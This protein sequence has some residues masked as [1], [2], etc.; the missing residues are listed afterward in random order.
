MAS[1]V[2]SETNPANIW[3][4][5]RFNKSSV[6]V[7]EP[8]LV[9]ITVYTSTWFTSP[10]QFSEIQVPESMMV[11]YEQRTGSM[12]K[13][14]GNKT[15]PAIE[16]KYVV[17]PFREG[18]NLFPALTIVTESPPEGDY[19]GKRRVVKSTER[20]FMVKHPPAGVSREKWLTAF[21]V[22]IS[23]TWNQPLSDLKQGDVLER[24]ITLQA[25]GAVAALIPPLDLPEGAFGNIYPKP[26]SLSNLQNEASFTGT[27]TETWTYL[28]ESEGSF[29]L[30]EVSVSWFD[31]G[32]DNLET[33]SLPEKGIEILENPNLDF[34]L[35]MQDSLRG[36]LEEGQS[37]EAEPF[38]FMGLKWWQLLIAVISGIVVVYLVIRFV[39]YVFAALEI[40]RKSK[41]DSEQHYFE[42]LQKAAMKEDPVAFM[43]QLNFWYDRFRQGKYRSAFK[44]F[45]IQTEE[46]DLVAQYGKLEK[47]IFSA[48]M[49][50]Q[51][52]GKAMY[53]SL[54]RLRKRSLP[55]Q[56]KK[57]MLSFHALNP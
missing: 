25:V 2:R 48:D 24:Q 50:G 30:P 45:I 5:V 6:A 1:P 12:R 11:N 13:T 51:W 34:L 57:I 36:I 32:K 33:T 39:I 52:S 55:V 17:Y 21:N 54:R 47:I 16:K 46:E 9:T 56:K 40:R 10:P 19:K 8:L 29:T 26:P 14:I 20:K 7:G 38:E 42:L 3:A 53:E 31:P 23:E 22:S 44:D 27:R 4:S 15:Y 28:L 35:T 18:E 49:T 43:R 37:A 41:V